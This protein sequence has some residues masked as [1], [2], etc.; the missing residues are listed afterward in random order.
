MVCSVV[1]LTDKMQQL[2]KYCIC[3]RPHNPDRLLV[4]CSNPNCERWLHAECL[5][6]A[7][8]QEAHKKHVRASSTSHDP[9]LA[10]R[11]K[12]FEEGD[13]AI[14]Q[15][16]DPAGRQKKGTATTVVTSKPTFKR[17]KA[18]DRIAAFRA[19]VMNEGAS[20]SITIY[21]LRDGHVGETWKEDLKC[22]FCHQV[23]V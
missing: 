16:P 20:Q 4:R 14:P 11:A 9:V 18:K 7:A 10:I 21:D 13:G 6:S 23:I 12:G 5:A 8:V 3:D 15:A 19:E 22:L 2:R 17:P 1:T